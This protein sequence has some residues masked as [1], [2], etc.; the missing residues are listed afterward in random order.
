MDDLVEVFRNKKQHHEFYIPIFFGNKHVIYGP[1][2][3]G[4]NFEIEFDGDELCMD[5]NAWNT[6]KESIGIFFK[7]ELIK[8]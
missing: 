8:S 4:E 7:K 5:R 3:I 6:Q 2:S 1:V